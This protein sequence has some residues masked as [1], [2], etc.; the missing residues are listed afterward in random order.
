MTAMSVPFTKIT[1]ETPLNDRTVWG[2]ILLAIAERGV[3]LGYSYYQT[4][5]TADMTQEQ[6]RQA[7]FNADRLYPGSLVNA[8]FFNAIMLH[9][10]PQV[11]GFLGAAAMLSATPSFDPTTGVATNWGSLSCYANALPTQLPYTFYQTPFPPDIEHVPYTPLNDLRYRKA[12]TLDDL[13]NIDA[14]PRGALEVGDIVGL[15]TLSDI[16]HLLSQVKF[17]QMYQGFGPFVSSIYLPGTVT[18]L[19]SKTVRIYR[20]IGTTAPYALE[21]SQEIGPTN[22]PLESLYDHPD[23]FMGDAGMVEYHWTNFSVQ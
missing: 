22:A 16:Q 4:Q 13:Q 5:Y 1:E 15:H 9:I 3:P 10:V 12:R 14:C 18:S 17:F 6:A 20:R 19:V 21:L 11:F 23:G 7:I 2:E 8:F